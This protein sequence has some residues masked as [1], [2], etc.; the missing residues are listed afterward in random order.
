MSDEPEL[1]PGPPWAMEEMILAEEE[2]VAPILASPQAAEAG[3]LIR[4]AAAAGEPV[5]L[6]G[7]GTSD[8]A[9]MAG[10]EMLRETLGTRAIVARDAFEASLDPQQGGVIAGVTHEAGTRATLAAVAA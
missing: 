6:T 8:H 3:A 4:R 10:A 9:A 5:V 1:R 2:L 7:C